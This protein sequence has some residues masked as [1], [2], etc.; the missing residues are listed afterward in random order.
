MALKRYSLQSSY[1]LKKTPTEEQ[2][3]LLG[4][5]GTYISIHSEYNKTVYP[6]NSMF[7]D[8][9]NR[10]LLMIHINFPLFMKSDSNPIE[11]N[12]NNLYNNCRFLI[13]GDQIE[14]ISK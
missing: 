3:C 6:K 13:R 8:K 10:L 12:T 7:L 1:H 5:Y 2:V 4:L 9:T 14:N 11:V